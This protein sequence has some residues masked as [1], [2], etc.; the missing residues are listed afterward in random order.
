MVSARNRSEHIQQS[1]ELS[2][3]SAG[4]AWGRSL[5]DFHQMAHIADQPPAS[6]PGA[7]ASAYF[8][9]SFF[10]HASEQRRKIYAGVARQ[11]QGMPKAPVDLHKHR[12]RPSL[13][14]VFHHGNSMP[15]QG[16]Q[17]RQGAFPN[18]GIRLNTH[19][20]RA[21]GPGGMNIT[22][23]AMCKLGTQFA[24]MHER[25][26]PGSFSRC[27]LLYQHGRGAFAD[28][29]VGRVKLRSVAGIARTASGTHFSRSREFL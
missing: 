28:V 12:R 17:N 9:V 15:A 25:E 16:R 24:V 29:V 4:I 2:R 1:A 19:S 5:P 18:L 11:R 6:D 22:N 7:I 3:I 20:H 27:E 23:P 14:A 10:R 26:I 13:L 21:S 8:D